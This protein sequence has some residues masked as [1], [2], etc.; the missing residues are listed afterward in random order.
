M[1]KVWVRNESTGLEREMSETSFK[2]HESKSKTG[3][4]A[5]R[6]KFTFLRKV[7]EPKSEIQ[8]AKEKLIA[9]KAAREAETKA[10]ITVG[11]SEPTATEVKKSPGRPKKQEA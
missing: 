2:Y 11:P 8:I 4:N 6:P 3:S 9:E 1:P 10:E 7:E 5:L